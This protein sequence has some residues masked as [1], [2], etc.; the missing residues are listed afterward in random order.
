M[1]SGV[2]LTFQNSQVGQ[3][4]LV[5]PGFKEVHAHIEMG[6]VYQTMLVLIIGVKGIDEAGIDPQGTAPVLVV[7]KLIHRP[8][9]RQEASEPL[10]FGC[11]ELS[12]IESCGYYRII[13][14][15]IEDRSVLQT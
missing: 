8:V 13:S 4:I 1:N 9:F 11:E 10:I 3:P 15:D 5:E 2:R 7:L 6:N 14:Y 12:L